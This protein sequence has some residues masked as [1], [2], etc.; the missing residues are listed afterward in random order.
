MAITT[1]YSQNVY[2]YGP[3]DL[4]IAYGSAVVCTFICVLWGC[5]T[6][7]RRRVSCNTDFST[8][9]RTTRRDE[10][11]QLV[12]REARA[13][14]APLPSHIKTARLIYI[15]HSDSREGGFTLVNPAA[16]TEGPLDSVAYEYAKI[17]SQEIS[18]VWQ[19]ESTNSEAATDKGSTTAHKRIRRKPVA[20]GRLS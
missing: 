6:L 1:W 3:T 7:H 12:P 9:L 19:H 18:E 17:G 4:Y 5:Y 2:V 13:G 8:I 14:N 10:F 15:K 11:A 20:S 16:D